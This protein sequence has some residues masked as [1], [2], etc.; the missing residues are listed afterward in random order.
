MEE[1]F[2]SEDHG[3]EHGAQRPHVE[4][5]IVFLIIDEEFGTF[6]ISRCDSNVV[7]CPLVVEFSQTP[8]DE[9]QLRLVSTKYSS[10]QG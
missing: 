1:R 2:F 6:E 9:P 4:R 8:V 5:V 10:T 7:L 3:C